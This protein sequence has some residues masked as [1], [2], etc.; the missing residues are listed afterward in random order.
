MAAAMVQGALAANLSL[1]NVPFS[2]SSDTVAAPQ[3]MG[4]VLTTVGSNGTTATGAAAEVGIPKAGLDG[5][6]VHATQTFNVAG[7]NLGT[8]SLNISSP[9][10]GASV[11]ALAAGSG[12]QADNM[13]LNAQAVNAATATLGGSATTPTTIGASADSVNSGTSGIKDGVPGAFGLNATG[14]QAALTGLDASANG[15]TIGGTISLPN[16]KIALATGDSKGTGA[17]QTASG[18]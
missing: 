10:T 8:Y 16:L 3:G 13:I 7:L 17:G 12:I 11:A 5:I 18:C 2:L 14:G 9:K 15:A 1:T 6:C 4:A